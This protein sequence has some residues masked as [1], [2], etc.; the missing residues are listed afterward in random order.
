MG[1]YKFCPV[2]SFITAAVIHY[3]RLGGLQTTKIHFPPFWSLEDQGQ[4]AGRAGARQ[5][6]LP[7]AQCNAACVPLGQKGWEISLK[8]LF[9]GHHHTRGLCPC[10]QITCQR[11]RLQTPSLWQIGLIW[12]LKK[13]EHSAYEWLLTLQV[14]SSFFFFFN[15]FAFKKLETLIFIFHRHL[16]MR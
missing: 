13:Q 16:K 7:S 14:N 12:I 6:L 11:P 10:D 15:K 9:W 4:G 5:S 3:H 1:L 8:P 2:S